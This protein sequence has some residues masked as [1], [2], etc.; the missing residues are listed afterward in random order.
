MKRLVISA[1]LAGLTFGAL[2]ADYTIDP[3]HTFAYFEVDHL[4][5]SKY[6]GR[7]DRTSG[8]ISF[9][10]V[11]QQGSVEAVIE[12]GSVSTGV[13]KLDQHLITP[14]FFDAQQFPTITFKS[15]EF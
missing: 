10:P 1:A 8:K 5:V 6:R 12:T 14:D 15:T 4:G 11:K 3:N 13:Q 7:F 2:A 9:D